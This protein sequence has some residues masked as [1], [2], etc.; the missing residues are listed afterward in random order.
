MVTTFGPGKCFQQMMEEQSRPDGYVEAM[1]KGGFA[2]WCGGRWSA[3]FTVRVS[4]EDY[5]RSNYGGADEDMGR[6]GE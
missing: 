3:F 1:P 2:V 4:A 5:S 6:T